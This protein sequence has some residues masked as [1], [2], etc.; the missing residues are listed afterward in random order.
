MR[1]NERPTLL[2]LGRFTK[3]TVLSNGYAWSLYLDEFSRPLLR[4]KTYTSL[5]KIGFDSC[6][7]QD[8]VSPL[9]YKYVVVKIDPQERLPYLSHVFLTG[10]YRV[11]DL[12][13]P[14]QC[15][16]NKK[17]YRETALRTLQRGQLPSDKQIIR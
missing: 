15:C 6:Q 12:S 1:M 8:I 11:M 14:K 4:Y 2:I 16:N 7:S 17:E 3:F 5:M 9:G 13:L 10:S